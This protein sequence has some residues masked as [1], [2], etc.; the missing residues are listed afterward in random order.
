MKHMIMTDLEGPA[1]V[2]R[3]SQTYGDEPF[4]IPAMH[5]LTQ[6]V[7]ACIQGILDADPDAEVIVFDGH[8]A[9]GILPDEMDSRGRYVRAPEDRE[10]AWSE[11]PECSTFM[12]V[13]QHA[14]A[15]M[16]NAP[17]CHTGSSKNV[18]YKRFNGVFI[19]E[20]GAG[21]IR[22]GH[23][24]VPMVFF[25][26]DDKAVVEAQGLIP[27]IYTVTTKWGTGWQKA[28]HLQPEE[29][30]RHIRATAA[31]AV[32]NRHRIQPLKVNPPYTYEVRYIH[33]RASFQTDYDGINATPLDSRTVLYRFDDLSKF[34]SIR[35]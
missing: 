19:G 1:G 4:K 16:P 13:G 8:G 32:R 24:G 21:A 30:R 15:C 7:N 35:A 23:Y 22:A 6:E 33:P 34:K 9:V 3:F 25:S 5:L 10:Q 17:L 12:Y 18:V 2:E 28:V 11:L 29:A 20:F 14:L 27:N 31:E 26:G